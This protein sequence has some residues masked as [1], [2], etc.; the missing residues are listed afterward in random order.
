MGSEMTEVEIK[1]LHKGPA[2]EGV[3]VRTLD[4]IRQ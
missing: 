2:P 3:I 1:G 4:L